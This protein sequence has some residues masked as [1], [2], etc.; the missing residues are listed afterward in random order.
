MTAD[1]T[2]LVALMA[3]LSSEKAALKRAT[4]PQEIELRKVWVSQCEKEINGEERFLGMS[5]TDFS[6][7]EMTDEE[8]MAELM[9]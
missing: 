4:K 9:A 5:V 7:P 3:R 8:L 1:T 2:H 6:E